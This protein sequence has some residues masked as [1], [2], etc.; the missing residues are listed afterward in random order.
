[1]EDNGHLEPLWNTFSHFHALLQYNNKV[2][3]IEFMSF[4]YIL[5]VL[6]L[7]AEIS[8]IMQCLF[9][10]PESTDFSYSAKHAVYAWTDIQ[11]NVI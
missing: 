3:F 10:W 6:L 2:E 1:M 4:P 11:I 9:E 5:Y 7:L 8:H